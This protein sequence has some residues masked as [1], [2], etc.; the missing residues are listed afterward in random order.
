MAHHSHPEFVTLHALRIK[1][2]APTPTL[3]EMAALPEREVHGHLSVLQAGGHVKFREQRE[4]WQLTPDGREHH[5]DRLAADVAASGLVHHLAEQYEE[6]LNLNGAFKQ[7]C[8]DW[9][10][11]DGAPNDHTDLAYDRDVI[12][13]LDALH[14]GARPVLGSVGQ[15]LLRLNPYA[16]RLDQVLHRV[17][18][19]E[20]KMFTGVMCGSYHDIWMEFHEDLILTQGISR[21]AEGSF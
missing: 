13:R 5:A 12:G 9:Q 4:L 21:A 10:L 1:G 14:A 6:F 11:R 15:M 8:T 17:S 2:F 16:P 3:A 18:S 19:G 7:L 20:H